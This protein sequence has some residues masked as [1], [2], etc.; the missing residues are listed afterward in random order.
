MF[1]NYSIFSCSYVSESQINGQ[2]IKWP[3]HQSR[4]ADVWVRLVILRARVHF[5]ALVPECVTYLLPKTHLSYTSKEKRP[6]RWTS[7]KEQNKIFIIALGHVV[8]GWNVTYPRTPGPTLPWNGRNPSNNSW[9]T[10]LCHF[11]HFV[12]ASIRQKT[13]FHRLR[14]YC[15]TDRRRLNRWIRI[16]ITTCY[17][18]SELPLEAFQVPRSL[19]NQKQKQKKP[20]WLSGVDEIEKLLWYQLKK[21]F[22]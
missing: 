12:M 17:H 6:T 7:A 19:I 4:W 15:L 18:L 16:Y 10:F 1:I 3:I 8:F 20:S 5:A 14:S 9:C 22:R 13:T 21:I 2:K 11:I